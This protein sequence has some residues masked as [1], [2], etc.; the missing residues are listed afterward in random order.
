MGGAWVFPGGAVDEADDL[1][2]ARQVVAGASPEMVRW[3]AAATRELVEETGIWLLE[4]GA[5]VSADRPS[6]NSVFSTVL[7]RGERFAVRS[8]QYFANWITPEPLPIR[9]DTRFFA[10]AVPAGLEP[11]VDRLEL[12]DAHW[13]DPRDAFELADTGEWEVAFPTRKILGFLEG[14][15]STSDLRDHI[16][17]RP[18]VE[19]IQPRLALVD[20]KI[21]ILMPGDP[22]FDDASGESEAALLSALERTVYSES[23]T[24]PETGPR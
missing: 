20:E 11:V 17:S 22:R 5:V 24:P 6:G 2:V 15:G 9:F 14:F 7:E 21:A 23:E 12:V 16:R 1:E 19:P 10:A 8:L 4:S 13:V 3:L 18:S